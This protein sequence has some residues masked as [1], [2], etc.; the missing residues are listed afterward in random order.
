M[1]LL[2]GVSGRWSACGW[3]VEQLDHDKEMG[4]M[5]RWMLMRSAYHQEDKADTL[6]SSLQKGLSGPT[7]VHVDNKGIID[8]LWRC[9]A[10]KGKDANCGF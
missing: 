5:V 3:S 4:P 2:L 10:P 8:V 9:I 7:T 1:V 6:L